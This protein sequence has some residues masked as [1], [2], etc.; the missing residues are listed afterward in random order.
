MTPV[1]E[2]KVRK[3]EAYILFYMRKPDEGAVRICDNLVKAAEEEAAALLR[4]RGVD[5]SREVPTPE[6]LEG[7]CYI[8]R[9]WMSKR[10]FRG[11][12]PP[13]DNRDLCCLHGVELPR[14]YVHRS[15]TI[16][17][18]AGFDKLVARFGGGP[19]VPV[20]S[21]MQ[22]YQSSGGVRGCSF[23]IR[24]HTGYTDGD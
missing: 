4:T 21:Q 2:D 20:N 14:A 1:A 22:C 24:V 15:G 8:S 3:Q 23:F 13:V 11:R 16:V 9:H 19:F 17:S 7:L 12:P 10:C 5:P 18:K 6:E